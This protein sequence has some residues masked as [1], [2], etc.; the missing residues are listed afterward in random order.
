MPE[1]VLS[2]HNMYRCPYTHQHSHKDALE[3]IV[4]CLGHCKPSEANPEVFHGG[5]SSSREQQVQALVYR[6]QRKGRL[7]G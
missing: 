1:D 2:V 7:L 3:A 5:I 4:V 6:I